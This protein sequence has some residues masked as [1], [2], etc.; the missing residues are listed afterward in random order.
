M[1]FRRIAAVATVSALVAT[2]CAGW[3]RT[4]LSE[5]DHLP[6]RQQIQ[7]WQNGLARVVHSGLVQH[8]TLY[9]VPFTRPPSCDSCRIAIPM[10]EVDS[11]LLGNQ[12]RQGLVVGLLPFAVLGGL[13]L[14]FAL[15]YGAD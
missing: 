1:R 13:I 10:S 6:P 9:A 3:R 7:V 5:G 11:V 4:Q 8:D 2:G 14:A 12:E 15:G